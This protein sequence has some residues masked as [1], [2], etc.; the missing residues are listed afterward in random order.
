[1][2]KQDQKALAKAGDLTDQSALRMFLGDRHLQS[3]TSL[4]LDDPEQKDIFAFATLTDAL[5]IYER[6]PIHISVWHVLVQR[7]YYPHRQTGEPELRNR[8]VIICDD[9][10]L[11]ETTSDFAIRDVE[12][13]MVLYGEPPYVPPR[14]F[15]FEMK[16]G[17]GT[18]RYLAASPPEPKFPKGD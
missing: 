11:F 6:C 15:I 10:E 9:G 5:P 14:T 3:Y 12:A 2:S 1:M 17:R 13:M 4:D 18:N 7:R 8:L 16:R